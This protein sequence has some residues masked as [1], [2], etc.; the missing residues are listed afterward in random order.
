[1]VA[2]RRP[3]VEDA[4]VAARL[5]PQVIGQAGM[6]TGRVIV[7]CGARGQREQRAVEVGADALPA[8]LDQL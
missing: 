6:E 3:V 1:M 5:E 4:A 2:G 8:K 7:L